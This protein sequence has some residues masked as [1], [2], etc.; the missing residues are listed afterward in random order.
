M[1]NILYMVNDYNMT[2]ALTRL[3]LGGRKQTTSLLSSS[4]TTGS[5]TLTMTQS[6]GMF[7]FHY[8]ESL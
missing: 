7:H 3:T 8:N 5:S 6:R 1:Y 2:K 4:Q